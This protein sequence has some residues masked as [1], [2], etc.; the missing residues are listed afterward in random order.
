MERITNNAKANIMKTCLLTLFLFGT[1][2]GAICQQSPNSPAKEVGVWKLG[3][4]MVESTIDGNT[5]LAEMQFDSL[6]AMAD[7]ID[8]QFLAIGLEVKHQLHKT[9][10]I[11]DILHTQDAAALQEVCTKQLL[12]D[13][14]PC[15]GLSVEFVDN[16]AL[17]LELIKMYVDDQ[18]ARG[19]KL[20][21]IISKYQLDTT[22][23]TPNGAVATDEK[24]RKRLQ[25]IFGEHGFPTRKLV[26][27]DAM[28][29]VFIL[30]QHADGDK[31][32]QKSQLPNIETAV[33]NGDMDGQNYAYL[34]DRIKVNSG[35]KQWYGTQ[36][37]KVD[38]INKTAELAETEAI[39]NLDERR[40]M[41]GMMPIDTYKRL[42]FKN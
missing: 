14:P 26:G 30:I 36:F 38:P 39:E 42:M 8:H 27:R 10:E 24:H 22:A 32:W 6:L 9:Q 40:R 28:F 7:P 20:E 17:Q 25:E 34:Y 5:G 4:R 41:I 37:S 12:A 31:E 11:S 13:A 33:K 3:W 29:G 2:F 15:T 19:N 23:I 18:A 1:R 16:K 21:E 35:E